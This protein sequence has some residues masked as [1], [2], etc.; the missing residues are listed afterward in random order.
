VDSGKR[1]LVLISG[2]GDGA[3][4]DFLRIVTGGKPAR[5]IY[6]HVALP[7]DLLLVLQSAQERGM[8]LF[9]WGCTPIH[10][11]VGLERVHREVQAITAET[12]HKGGS[13]LRQQLDGLLHHP[14]P[15]IR[16]LYECTHFSACYALNRF[17]VLLLARYLE[18]DPSRG[19]VLLEGKRVV[20][21]TST[22]SH[23]CASNP[24]GCHGR[25]HEV[26]WVAL[27]DCREGQTTPGGTF[28]AN[29]LVI[30]HGID[31]ADYGVPDPTP[32]LFRQML[33]FTSPW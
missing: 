30:R 4:Q 16:L 14:V 9:N 15:S 2:S 32:P 27:P 33:P 19:P 6:D 29:V 10:D 12:L 13:G 21:I 8:R 11:H 1:P 26:R 17:L 23:S 24:T 5:E 18:E 28:L 22:D 31:L 20:D 7:P 3:L 25:M